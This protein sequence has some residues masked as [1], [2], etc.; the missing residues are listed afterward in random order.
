MGGAFGTPIAQA[1]VHTMPP[2]ELFGT[3]GAATRP[4]SLI[5]MKVLNMCVDQSEAERSF[6]RQGD[7]HSKKR[8]KIT[9]DNFQSLVWLSTNLALKH[10]WFNEAVKGTNASQQEVISCSNSAQDIVQIEG[11]SESTEVDSISSSSKYMSGTDSANVSDLESDR[12]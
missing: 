2:H 4:F 11:N 10:R 1:A 12:D 7:I 5:A 3:F 9:Q 6:K 8:N